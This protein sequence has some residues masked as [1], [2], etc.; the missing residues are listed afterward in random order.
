[1]IWYIARRLLQMIPVFLGATLLIYAMAFLSGGDPI[2][3]ISG[4]KPLSPAIVAELRRQYN[5]DKPLIV[6]W[7][8][9]LGHL[10]QGDLGVS[11]QGRPII[12]D[13]RD[14]FPVTARLA[15]IAVVIETVCGVAAGV[16]SGLRKGTIIDTAFLMVSLL[17]IAIPTFVIGFVTQ[18]LLG[19]KLQWITVNASGGDFQDLLV[20]GA[21]LGIVSFAYVLRLTR[22]SVAEAATA[23][24]V[25]TAT[26]KGLSRG[27]VVSKHI[28]RNSLIPVVTYIGADLG[29]LMG[30][31]IVTER[32]FNIH[33]IGS[34]LW[35]AITRSDSPKIVTIVT[36]LVVVFLISNL[37]V[38]LLYAVLDPRIR[39]AK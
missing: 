22:T 21:V 3:A 39:Y 35:T 16:I 5:L 27:G 8:I 25:R 38:D 33:G 32:I 20:P 13:L 36:L 34:E 15:V 18:Y 31:A 2:A 6:Q 19:V 37:I 1:M 12:D 4:D 9:Y 30:G 14:A 17:V 23:D 26:A 10:F 28:L 7:L 24:H 11:L 29:A